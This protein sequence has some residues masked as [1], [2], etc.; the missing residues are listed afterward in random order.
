MS[1]SN[2]IANGVAGAG[3][4][5]IAQI[6]TYPLQ[7]VNTRQQTERIAKSKPKPPTAAAGT[8]LQI[9]HVLRTEG[10]GGLY[11]GLK[12]SLFGTAA[13]QPPWLH[14]HM[15]LFTDDL[16]AIIIPLAFVFVIVFSPMQ[17]EEAEELDRSSM[18]GLSDFNSVM[19]DEYLACIF[20]F[21][22]PGN[23]KR[24]SLVCRRWLRT[25]GQSRHRLSLNAQSDLQHLIPFI[26]SRFDAVTKLALKC[27]RS[28][29][30]IAD[31]ALVLI[32][33]R[34]Q[35]LTRLKLRTWR[36]L[37]DAGMSAFSKNCRGLKKLLCGSCT[38]RAKSM[39]AMLDHCPAL[40]E[41]FVKR[42]RGIIDG[43]GAELIGPE[44]AAAALKTI[45]MK[46]LYNGQCFGPLI[47]GAKNLKSLKL[48][49]CSGDWD[50]L[51]PLIVDR[52]TEFLHLVKAPECTNAGL[53]AVAGKSLKKLCIKSCPVSDH[54]MEALASGCPNFIKVKVKKCRG[55]TSEGL[56]WL[57]ASRGSLAINL[58][59][60]EQLDGIYYYFYQLFKN[61]AEAIAAARKRHERGDGSAGF[62]SW[63]VVAA[64]AGSAVSMPLSM[65]LVQ[66]RMCRIS[67]YVNMPMLICTTNCARTQTQAE[68][69]FMESRK[70]AL[71]KEASEN[72]LTDSTLQEKLAELDST[73]PRSYGTIQ[74]AREVYAEAGIKGFWKG[75][76]PTLIMVCN[77]SIQFMIYETL[78]KRLKEKRS[79]DNKH[80]LKNVSALEVFLLGALAKLGATVTTYPLLV[81]KSRLQ[82]KQEIGGHISLRYSGTF[83]A[84]IKMMRYEG[85]PGYYKGMST[86]IVQSVFAAS[87]LFMFKEEIVKAYIF[88]FN[89][90]GK[91]KVPLN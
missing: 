27:D 81:V 28:S 56:E 52:V 79:A 1:N 69:K 9:L 88:L 65:F 30:S 82:A 4:G 44:V 19:H 32:S 74:A 53:G 23:Q 25:E 37:T 86:K 13:S 40:E 89:K 58:D 73:K 7:T 16:A 45:F 67:V 24:C 10:W 31:E 26:F 18:D 78:L 21:L 29:V 6:L 42:L 76:I 51:F 77:P 75:I 46:E 35:N 71:L 3:A 64:L 41:L 66:L 11:S 14:S 55:V 39:N 22:S 57:R 54:G 62:F 85:L 8:L 15:V 12:P 70:E 59:T 43:A 47:I 80:E 63:L 83:D 2:A 72:S 36:D 49:R 84:I 60:G 20:Q 50:K 91:A 5:I 87:V 34:C 17:S 48:F 90:I 61:K 33:E 38:F 68:R